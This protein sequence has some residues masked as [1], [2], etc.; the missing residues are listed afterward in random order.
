MATP[1]VSYPYRPLL[2][3][4]AMK[5]LAD[6]FAT[7]MALSDEVQ[8]AFDARRRTDPAHTVRGR[9]FLRLDEGAPVLIGEVVY[10][11]AF[12]TQ[13]HEYVCKAYLGADAEQLL[14]RLAEAADD[15]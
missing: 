14:N 3:H 5:D 13:A 10:S 12:L 6:I 11:V 2:P 9:F 15:L 1:L 4:R 8:V 7:T